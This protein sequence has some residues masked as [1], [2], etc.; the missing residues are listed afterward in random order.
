MYL[1]LVLVGL[2]LTFVGW[3]LFRPRSLALTRPRAVGLALV[4]VGEV[5]LYGA[6]WW[7]A[8]IGLVVP[9]FLIDLAVGALSAIRR[10][11]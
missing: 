1:V 5:L 7:W 8:L 4:L 3:G 11:R 9:G 10:T 2:G 6:A